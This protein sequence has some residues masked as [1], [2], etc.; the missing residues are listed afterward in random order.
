MGKFEW[1]LIQFEDGSN[2]Y[3]C[4]TETEFD[5]MKNKYNL[6][7]VNGNTWLAKRFEA[8]SGWLE[9]QYREIT[10]EMREYMDDEESI[11]PGFEFEGGFHYLSDF[12]RTH[13]NPWGGLDVPDYI[14]GYD[15]TNIYNP[16]FIEIDNGGEAVRVYEHAYK[17]CE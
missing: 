17:R 7:Y 3:I 6:E 1:Q 11:Q 16:L 12:V 2:P 9:I 4:K 14:H 5:R 13:N 10:E 15:A 8:V